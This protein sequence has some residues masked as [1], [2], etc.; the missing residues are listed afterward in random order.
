MQNMDCNMDC[1]KWECL[2]YC[3]TKEDCYINCGIQPPE[4]L[5]HSQEIK[6]NVKE[7]D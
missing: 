2:L 5:L 6:G 1:L 7:I 3:Q 4:S